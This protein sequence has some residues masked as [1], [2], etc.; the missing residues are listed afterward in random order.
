MKPAKQSAPVKGN[1]FGPW[2]ALLVMNVASTILLGGR[3]IVT[4]SMFWDNA[5]LY[6]VFRGNAHS[7]NHFGEVM[8]WN[9]TTSM[10]FPAFYF[11]HLGTDTFTPLSAAVL[12]VSW[13]LGRIGIAI[14]DFTHLY[15]I[16]FSFLVPLLFSVAAYLLASQ[17]FRRF[18]LR[19]LVIIM[20]AFSPG[21]VF[22]YSDNGLEQTSYGILF[23]AAFLYFY[24]NPS[25]KSFCLLVSAASIV[26][27][28]FNHLA[29]YWNLIFIP[30]FM[31]SVVV[32]NRRRLTA[33][34]N[35]WRA[36]SWQGWAVGAVLAGLC[37]MPAAISFSQGH[38]I[39]RTRNFERWYSFD[40]L[41]AGNPLE[42]MTVST[43]GMRIRLGTNTRH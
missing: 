3:F 22:N 4:R 10:G 40:Y 28:A 26:A 19:L 24:R 6:S 38:D 42:L 29:L 27:I 33:W 8:W 7:L 32:L 36:V 41:Q 31:I 39:L 18:Y 15:I 14:N 9:P 2:I 35:A 1:K 12:F 34:R 25:K 5:K 17:L 37:L 21:V 11:S 30:L 16:Y 23:C 20:T 43:P 13:L